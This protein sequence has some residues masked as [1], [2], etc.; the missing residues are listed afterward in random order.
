MGDEWWTLEDETAVEEARTRNNEGK[1]DLLNKKLF[2]FDQ[3]GTTYI[4]FK[5]LPGATGIFKFIID[6]GRHVVFIS[7]N[8]SVSTSTYR[9]KLTDI[10]GINI[11][12][13]QVHTSTS[14]TIQYLH[15]K[16][17]RN[18]YALGTPDFEQE[19]RDKGINITDSDPQLI[20]VAFDKTLTYEK[21]KKACLMIL[22][23]VEYIATHPDNVCPTLE[24]NIP[25]TGSFLA[26]IETATG[27]KPRLILGKPSQDMVNTVLAR[28][29]LSPEDAI[30]F[31]DRI[32]TDILM[33]RNSRIT[34]AL[35]L[36]G[37]SRI[38]DIHKFGIE[39]DFV[40][41]DLNE[42]LQLMKKV[43]P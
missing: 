1:K 5:P 18:V 26:L 43:I 25:D 17:I 20:V 15:S 30:I 2:I 27:Q 14:A 12:P 8:S 13:E 7:N 3:D 23:G 28:F 42:V 10:L 31:G 29:S 35:M 11:A 34:T 6:S 37:E 19:L 32:Y 16:G 40:F 21:L 22:K 36:T 41:R 24:G 38:E 9:K 33:G 39:S 4:D